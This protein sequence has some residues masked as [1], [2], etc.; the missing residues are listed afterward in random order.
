MKQI[1]AHFRSVTPLFLGGAENTIE[2]ELRPASIKGVLRFWW[3]TLQWGKEIQDS[4]RLKKEEDALFGSSE[5]GQSQFLL[6]VKYQQKP[7]EI[8]QGSVLSRDGSGAAPG[9]SKNKDKDI[10]GDGSRYL[11]YGLME[12]FSSKKK[13]T[14][15]GQLNRPC[16]AAPFE[17]TVQIVF[18]SNLKET[19][20]T[21][22]E[23]AL[24]LL[25]LC[26]GLGSR[27]RRGWGSLTLTKIV[28]HLDG[29]ETLWTAPTTLKEYEATLRH[30]ID[31]Q[32]DKD[33]TLPEWTA[34]ATGLSKIIL[35]QDS[36]NSPLQTLDK[37]GRDFVFFRSWGKNGKV[38]NKPR[39]G[40]FQFDHDLFKKLPPR[41]RHTEHPQRIVFGLPQNYGG[42]EQDQVLPASENLTRRSS[43][44]FFH[45]HQ[46]V[47]NDPPIGVLTYLPSRF[48]PAEKDRVKFG[49]SP[50][51]LAHGGVG[52]FW[53]PAEDFFNR[54]KSVDGNHPVTP[55]LKPSTVRFE[56]TKEV[57]L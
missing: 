12:A 10:V 17:F 24:K 48:L 31:S 3:R 42:Y 39:E 36:V 44:L 50:V 11:G 57:I 32:K 54:I 51:G 33:Q 34:F 13:D 41:N 35:L 38:L 37:M 53:K 15:A 19:R 49:G 16:F 55:P 23:N 43:P 46:I 29:E 27:S 9:F 5:Q 4:A 7:D 21:E 30:I 45:V 52:D 25:G 1:T 22:I 40:N 14:K 20:T 28:K 18:Q 26:G 2:T 6:T 47:P 56:Q 8:R